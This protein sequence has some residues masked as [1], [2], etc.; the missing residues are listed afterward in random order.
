MQVNTPV[1]LEV[2]YVP[3]THKSDTP[4]KRIDDG[5]VQSLFKSISNLILPPRKEEKE[6]ELK[7]IQ[8]RVLETSHLPNTVGFSITFPNK[9]EILPQR[10]IE[11][12]NM[13]SFSE[14]SISFEIIANNN[15]IKIQIVC[16]EQ[17]KQR[18]TSHL[19][20]YFPTV[21]LQEQYISDFGFEINE[22]IAIA[23]FGINDEFMRPIAMSE[24]FAI[25]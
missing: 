11:F 13:L 3:F 23:D 17:D 25:E 21:I 4:N 9:Q 7:A 24:S 5:K 2:P 1:D 22:K 19:K 10:N 12:L 20:A 6:E 18:I 8:P 15:E 14:H 16:S